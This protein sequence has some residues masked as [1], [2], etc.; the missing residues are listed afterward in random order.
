MHGRITDLFRAWCK[1]DLGVAKTK[2]RDKWTNENLTTNPLTS[3]T[4]HFYQRRTVLLRFYY[5]EIG[6]WFIWALAISN[7]VECEFP[8][9]ATINKDNEIFSIPINFFIVKY[10][11]L[12]VKFKQ[13]RLFFKPFSKRNDKLDGREK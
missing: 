8:F 9:L 10:Q 3:K 12:G 7:Q 11:I 6:Q 1:N 4:G 2:P 5:Y 13:Y